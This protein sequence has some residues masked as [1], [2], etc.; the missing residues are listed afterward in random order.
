MASENLKVI[1]GLLA[2]VVAA[3]ILVIA[4]TYP[5]RSVIGILA[6]A[7]IG[8]LIGGAGIRTAWKNW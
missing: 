5:T 8:L 4:F 7:T 2:I 1:L 3:F 6:V